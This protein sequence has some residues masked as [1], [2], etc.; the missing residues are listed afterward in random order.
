[1]LNNF[2]LKNIPS[3]MFNFIKET[4]DISCGFWPYVSLGAMSLLVQQ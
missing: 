4:A 2:I 3:E 1:L